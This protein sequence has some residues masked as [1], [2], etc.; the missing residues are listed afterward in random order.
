MST[1]TGDGL[2]TVQQAPREL[3]DDGHLL[4]RPDSLKHP[5]AVTRYSPEDHQGNLGLFET[6]TVESA[7]ARLEDLGSRCEP[8]GRGRY[9]CQ[10][11]L[12]EHDDQNPSMSLAIGKT[13]QIVVR[14]FACGPE[15]STAILRS[16]GPVHGKRRQPSAF[17]LVGHVDGCGCDRGIESVALRDK[18]RKVEHVRRGQ[19]VVGP[20][21]GVRMG[22]NKWAA[23][24]VAVQ[25]FNTRK[26]LNHEH[27]A[28]AFPLSA[29]AVSNATGMTRDAAKDALKS[30]RADGVLVKADELPATHKGNGTSLYAFVLEVPC[31]L[32]AGNVEAAPA[33]VGLDSHDSTTTS[34]RHRAV[35]PVVEEHQVS[36]VTLAELTAVSRTRL[37]TTERGT[38]DGLVAHGNPLYAPLPTRGSD[39]LAAARNFADRGFKVFPIQAGS[40]VPYDGSRG[41]LNATSDRQQ[42][43]AWF[44][45]APDS[46]L[47]IRTGAESGI[48]VLDVDGPA[49]M[50]ALAELEESEGALPLTARVFTPS[51]GS[52]FYFQ[53]PGIPIRSDAGIAPSIDVRGEGGYVVAPPSLRD[54]GRSYFVVDADAPITA[55]PDWLVTLVS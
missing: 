11:P 12:P 25:K 1:A 45:V 22:K 10:C 37:A 2:T 34:D 55:M 7:V 51:G 21:P 50:Q 19:V 47:A 36:G 28:D 17:K 46:N 29:T 48:V 33:V 54:D 4:A 5:Q 42:L 40:K 23:L 49:G 3:T 31:P 8:K 15:A 16:I 27:G 32:V 20:R 44:A 52:H 35:E 53:H 14:C 39:G 18:R 38:F 41:L 13:G 9:M 43:E 24:R 30:L 6:H 26:W